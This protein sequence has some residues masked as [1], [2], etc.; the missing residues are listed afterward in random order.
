[1]GTK[2]QDYPK[3]TKK[4]THHFQKNLKI[5]GDKPVVNIL[6]FLKNEEQD[7]TFHHGFGWIDLT[8]KMEVS[9]DQ[10]FKIASITK[11]FTSVVILQLMEENKID[12]DEPA[13]TY[14]KDLEYIRFDSL[15]VF[16]NKTYGKQLTIRQLLSHRSGLADLFV[17]AEDQFNA[18]VIENKQEKWEPEK[19]FSKY[20]EF[21]VNKMAK[22]EP[23][24][25]YAYTD[26]GY[27]LLGLCIEQITGTSL[28]DQYRIRI[29]EPLK[30]DY[31]FYEYHDEPIKKIEQAH[32]YIEEM[33][34]T[35][36]LNTS[37]D[38]AGGGLVSNT[39]DLSV[40]IDNL[41]KNKLF[42][43][44]NTLNLMIDNNMYGYGISIFTFDNK[45]YFG[46]LGFW[47][48]GVFYNPKNGITIVLSI[49]QVNPPFNSLKFVKK[50]IKILEK[51]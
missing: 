43:E 14:L 8:E 32:A 29:I 4:L 37:Y 13:Y 18:Y 12:L 30:M 44:S 24:E 1:M 49:N 26:V 35:A 3:K 17:D 20:Y 40:F 38:W 50:V 22:F 5:N 25:S 51:I 41:F 28:A 15:L 39:Y 7:Y 9:K 27:F 48:S 36:E 16:D 6:A 23:G 19:L 33:D 47:G 2:S 31:T 45:K 34:A 11:M 42:R 10:T 46:H 21:G